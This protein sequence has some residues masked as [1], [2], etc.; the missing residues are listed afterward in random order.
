MGYKTQG[1]GASGLFSLDDVLNQTGAPM[2]GAQILAYAQNKGMNLGNRGINSRSMYIPDTVNTQ[3]G[4]DEVEKS[5]AEIVAESGVPK[6]NDPDEIYPGSGDTQGSLGDVDL[7][8]SKKFS[9]DFGTNEEV[10]KRLEKKEVEEVSFSDS[11]DGDVSVVNES[12]LS[13]MIEKY[14]NLL[15]SKKAFGRDASDMLL[16]FAGAEGS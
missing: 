11:A 9:A 5:Y 13:S 8:G 16:G 10:K 6:Y 12:D 3:V 15:G 4:E 14:E 2:T 1:P 7:D